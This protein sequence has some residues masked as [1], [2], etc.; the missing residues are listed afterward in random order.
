MSPGLSQRGS[1]EGSSGDSYGVTWEGRAGTGFGLE[2]PRGSR[3][4]GGRIPSVQTW[5]YQGLCGEGARPRQHGVRGGGA[6]ALG[7]G[8]GRALQGSAAR[9]PR[10]GSARWFWAPPRRSGGFLFPARRLLAAAPPPS[11]FSSP[12]LR[13][14]ARS[15]ASRPASPRGLTPARSPS[16]L[17]LR[18]ARSRRGARRRR[19]GRRRRRERGGAGAGSAGRPLPGARQRRG[20]ARGAAPGGRSPRGCSG[21]AGSLAAAEKSGEPAPGQQLPGTGTGCG[22]R[23]PGAPAQQLQSRAAPWSVQA[24]CPASASGPGGG[25]CRVTSTVRGFAEPPVSEPAVALQWY[26][27]KLRLRE[28]KG[29]LKV[30]GTRSAVSKSGR[31]RDRV[32]REGFGGVDEGE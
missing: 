24:E 3:C 31:F 13:G 17:S 30:T 21:C 25:S 15:A 28:A 8:G 1:F 19:R 11:P 18:G 7:R 6:E 5:G 26:V 29:L 20:C 2:C 22:R 12:S 10:G 4:Q 32:S 14:W 16:P 23:V 27:K 9:G